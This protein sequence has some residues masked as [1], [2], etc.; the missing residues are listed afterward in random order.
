[1]KN[2]KKGNCYHAKDPC[3]RFKFTRFY[4][5][6]IN[7]HKRRNQTDFYAFIGNLKIRI[8]NAREEYSTR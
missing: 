2:K 7:T 8:Q 1:M 6:P 3:V 4:C 5:F